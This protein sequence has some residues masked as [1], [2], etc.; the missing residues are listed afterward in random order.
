MKVLVTGGLGFIGSALVRKLLRRGDSVLNVDTMTYAA[1]PQNVNEVMPS[2]R[3]EFAKR[4]VAD[5]EAFADIC[6][7]YGPDAI[8]HLAAH[9]HVDNS[10][11]EPAPF[12]RANYLGTVSVL[13]ATKRLGCRVL[14]VSTDEVYG[15][16]EGAEPAT[17]N[18]AMKPSSPYSASKAAA[19]LV[20]GAYRRTYGVDVVVA[21]PCN[22]YG[23][24]QHPEKMVPKALISMACGSKVPLYGDGQQVRE[25]LYVEDCADALLIL[26]EKGEA[27]EAYNVGSG[28]RLSNVELLK[29]LADLCGV[30]Y[31]DS[32]RPVQD[33]PGHDRKYAMDS[34]RLAALGWKPGFD[35]EEG[36][37]AT[38]EWYRRNDWW[39]RW[40][41]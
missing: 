6:L 12:Y 41:L 3:Y 29:T 2:D 4:D 7:R 33:R 26:L 31:A 32:I 5:S 23:P 8:A 36:F 24:Y 25:W 14:C 39:W 21:R 38:A 22:C 37:A 15:D 1:D 27:G 30:R 13:E 19:D 10:I 28:E 34:S 9:S 11:K 35:P 40:K 18:T 20:C 16:R 17:E